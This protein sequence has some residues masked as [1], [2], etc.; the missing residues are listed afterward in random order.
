MNPIR[1]LLKPLS[2]ACACIALVWLLLPKPMLLNGVSF[3]QIVRDRN[4]EL[5]RI[6]LTSDQKFRI[7]TPLHEIAPDFIDATLQYEDRYFARHPGVNPIALTRSAFGMVRG[8]ARTGA[9][10]I[11]IGFPI[12]EANCV[13]SVRRPIPSGPTRSICH[14][15]TLWVR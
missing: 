13:A 1:R 9:S 3:S 12:V 11:T 4:G 7:W 5:L 6:T 15:V 8:G 2:L 10:T 14:G